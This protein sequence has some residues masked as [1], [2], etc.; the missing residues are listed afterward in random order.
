MSRSKE[1]SLQAM[2]KNMEVN[3]WHSLPQ[4]VKK[5]R[6]AGFRA[7]RMEIATFLKRFINE[8]VIE[9]TRRSSYE[10]GFYYKRTYYRKIEDGEMEN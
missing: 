8:G 1:H 4:L 2:V 3:R 5:A 10:L 7:S 9:K 6:E